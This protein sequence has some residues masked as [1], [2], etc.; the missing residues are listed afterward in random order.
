M[1]YIYFIH[2]HTHTHT[3]T[4]YLLFFIIPLNQMW[5]K[6]ERNLH[7]SCCS[8]CLRKEVLWTAE[9]QSLVILLSGNN[10]TKTNSEA[11]R[12]SPWI[13]KC[14]LTG[15]DQ[16]IPEDTEEILDN[17]CLLEPLSP[18]SWFL[19]FVG[20]WKLPESWTL[21][22]LF[23]GSFFHSYHFFVGSYFCLAQ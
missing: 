18:V 19:S 23:L 5:N 3:H 9:L 15:S 12:V 1:P 14:L 2:T 8:L 4:N 13:N 10:W 11:S 16:Y 17:I 7:S 6:D 20:L 21:S 22:G